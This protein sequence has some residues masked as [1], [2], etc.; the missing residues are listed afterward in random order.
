MGWA[1]VWILPVQFQ[2]GGKVVKINIYRQ[3]GRGKNPATGFLFHHFEFVRHGERR[4]RR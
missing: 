3:R 4:Q 2:T 1:A